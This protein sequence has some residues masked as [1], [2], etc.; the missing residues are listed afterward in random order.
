MNIAVF[1][2][3]ARYN[4][5]LCNCLLRIC[6]ILSLIVLR[7]Q[8]NTMA[9]WMQNMKMQWQC[10]QLTAGWII[11][12]IMIYLYIWNYLHF[13]LAFFLTRPWT[14]VMMKKK[15]RQNKRRRSHRVKEE[16]K[17]KQI[18]MHQVSEY[19]RRM[20]HLV[21]CLKTAISALKIELS[22]S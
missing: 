21:S 22:C 15:E 13:F 20:L 16:R 17:S 12:W 11:F 6:G 1:K 10:S 2:K 7:S 4:C 18:Q 14:S 3:T 19:Y 8:L 9:L 5:E